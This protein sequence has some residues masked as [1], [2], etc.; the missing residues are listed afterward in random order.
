MTTWNASTRTLALMEFGLRTTEKDVSLLPTTQRHTQTQ[1]SVLQHTGC[2]AEPRAALPPPAGP[3]GSSA[4]HLLS[5]TTYFFFIIFFG[6]FITVLKYCLA[7]RISSRSVHTQK[8]VRL[9]FCTYETLQ[10]MRRPRACGVSSMHPVLHWT[11]LSFLF[12]ISLKKQTKTN[13]KKKKTTNRTQKIPPERHFHSVE[14]SY[15]L[16]LCFLCKQFRMQYHT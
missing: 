8:W 13:T 14:D 1:R 3:G 10:C 4:V 5:H 15:E 7:Y 11:T 9:R 12:T 2:P 6:N 16:V